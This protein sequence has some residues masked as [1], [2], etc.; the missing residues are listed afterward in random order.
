MSNELLMAKG[1]LADMEKQIE[2]CELKAENYMIT[3]RELLD[4]YK[5]F[6]DL[7]LDTVLLLTQDFRALQLRARELKVL[8]EK[9]K[10][11]FN[12]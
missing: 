9:L 10:D 6:C 4:P 1:R 2:E 5:N 8:R 11:N 12:L 7:Q 3:I